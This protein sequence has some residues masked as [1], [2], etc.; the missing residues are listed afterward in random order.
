MAADLASMRRT[1]GVVLGVAVSS[2]VT[3]G[4]VG[5]A[6][7]SVA[8]NKMAPWL[9]GRAAGVSSYL[10]IVALVVFG[11]LLSHPR[12]AKIRRIRPVTR[13]RAHVSLAVFTLA[14]T[15]LHIVALASDRY[16][17]VG[18]H[19]AF[20]PG[21][22]AYRP[23]PVTL[24]VIGLYAGLLAGLTAATAGRLAG[25]VWWPIHKVAIVSLLLVW[26]HGVLAGSDTPAL[27]AMYAATGAGVLVLAASRYTSRTRA[28]QVERQRRPAP[29]LGGLG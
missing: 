7:S 1:S 27:V 11:L 12:A 4:L 5:V 28:D 2:A 16:A 24:G 9:L 10:L 19:G 21:V 23:L 15:V 3:S 20:I 6:V 25:R 18:W 26:L 22:A 17:G 14:F 29:A 13:L 8:G